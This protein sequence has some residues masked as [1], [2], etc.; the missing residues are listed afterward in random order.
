MVGFLSAPSLFNKISKDEEI[1]SNEN[2][3]KSMCEQEEMG[4]NLYWVGR[5]IP[6]ERWH[7][8][9]SLRHQTRCS[10]E[11]GEGICRGTATTGKD[12]SLELLLGIAE[13][14]DTIRSFIC[15]K[16]C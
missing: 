9:E 14:T 12:P 16:K 13:A 3:E 7:S 11:W 10:C 6:M 15:P 8:A 4:K 1:V 2:C 5:E